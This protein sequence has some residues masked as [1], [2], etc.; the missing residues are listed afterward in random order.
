MCK[1][2]QCLNNTGLGVFLV[3]SYILNLLH[4]SKA[5]AFPGQGILSVPN[6]VVVLCC[7]QM[8]TGEI[9]SSFWVMI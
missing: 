9:N 4:P 1:L 8:R 3:F 5:T 2:V 7:E 6:H